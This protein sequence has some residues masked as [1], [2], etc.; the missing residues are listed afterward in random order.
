MNKREHLFQCLQE[1]AAEV[2]QVLSK[3]NRFGLTNTQP[4]TGRFNLENL[5]LEL[6]DMTAI[7]ELLEENGVPIL[8]HI[9]GRDM[10]D[11]K[12][13]KVLEHIKIARKAGTIQDD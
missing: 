1:E 9:N 13:K 10:I 12:K 8:D 3:I 5:V 11:K 6:T 4:S 2:I 7:L